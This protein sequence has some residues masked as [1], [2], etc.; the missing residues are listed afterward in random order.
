MYSSVSVLIP[1]RHRLERLQKVLDSFHQ[2]VHGNAD[3]VFRVDDDDHA[4]QE[5]LSAYRV[6]VG[7]RLGG[8]QSMPAFINEMY[9]ASTGDVLLV[10]NDDM[11]FRTD[12]WPTIVLNAANEYPDGLFDFGVKT[13]NEKNFVWSIVSRKAADAL[14]H[15]W[16]PGI[17]WGDIYLRD[18]MAHFGRA[19]KLRTVHIEHDWA[20]W[21]PDQV[22]HESDKEILRRDPTYWQGTHAQAV[23]EGVAKL[24]PLFKSVAGLTCS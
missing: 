12:D 16:H 11:I 6:V 10:G 1:T 23:R 4:S 2:T 13:H 7:P 9:R 22:F 20:G 5:F 8:Y 15:L 17:F 14:G 3:L 21:N 19:I 24:E 18:L